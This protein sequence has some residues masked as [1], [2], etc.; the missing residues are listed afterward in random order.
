MTTLVLPADEEGTITAAASIILRGGL[1]VFPTDT[2][3]GVGGHPFLPAAAERIYRAKM[4]PRDKAIPLLVSGPE[5]LAQVVIDVPSAARRLMAAFWPGALTVVLP[6]HPSVPDV[7]TAGRASVALRM[8]DHP[9]V[10]ALAEAISAPVAATSANLSGRP[11]ATTATQAEKALGE[12][13]DLVIEGGPCSGGV[14]S[15]VLDLTMRPPQVVRPGAISLKEL[16]RI[17]STI[18]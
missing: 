10:A 8:P 3:Y 13:V 7:L 1:V 11:P 16:R 18:V 4:R 2:V 12:V 9:L 17:V 5:Q 6:K 14:P 15:T